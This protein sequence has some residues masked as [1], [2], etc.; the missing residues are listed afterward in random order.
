MAGPKPKPTKLKVLEGNPGHQ[1]LNKNEPIPRPLT[2]PRPD[3]GENERAA[4][5]WDE[6]V[7]VLEYMGCLTEA[8]GRI[9][10]L[11]CLELATVDLC[12]S[13]LQKMTEDEYVYETSNGSQAP[14]AWLKQRREASKSAESLMARLGLSPADRSK[15][16]VKKPDAGTSP[17]TQV[18]SAT[19]R[20][21]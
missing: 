14:A 15:I 8:D 17:L 4:H 11:L 1:K 10:Y 19:Q 2:P 5:H 13:M 21:R 12:E 9:L 16:E 18:R 6:L 20:R 3:F 7:P